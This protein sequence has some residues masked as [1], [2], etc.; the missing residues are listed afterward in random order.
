MDGPRSFRQYRAKGRATTQLDMGRVMVAAEDEDEIREL[1][2]D[3]LQAALDFREGELVRDAG[4]R[5][6]WR[7]DRPKGALYVKIYKRVPLHRRWFLGG[8]FSSPA[9]QEWDAVNSLRQYGF[10]MPEAVAVG[11][12]PSMMGVSP[13]SFIVTREVSGRP[14]DEVLAEGW[15]DPHGLGGAQAR[16]AVVKDVAGMVRRFHACGFYHRDL[17]CGHLI[18]APDPRWGRPFIIDLQRVGQS[19][20]PRRRWLIKDLAAL[21]YSAPPTVS[22]ADRLRFLL[23][24]LCK[25]RVDPEAR[26]WVRQVR[27]KVRQ[28]ASHRPKYG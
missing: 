5:C 20:P 4:P 8:G 24:Y 6:T 3:T 28:I 2:L 13:A 11:E 16:D 18:V 19:F 9:R 27:D 10:D 26:R 1:G 17:Y 25:S 7:V 14:L 23:T 12:A 22:R 21:D 15:P